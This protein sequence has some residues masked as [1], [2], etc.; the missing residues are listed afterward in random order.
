MSKQGACNYC[1]SSLTTSSPMPSC[2]LCPAHD[3]VHILVYM[4]PTCETAALKAGMS[5]GPC[6]YVLHAVY[7]LSDQ[8]KLTWDTAALKAG[9][10]SGP[11]AHTCA[12]CRRPGP[13]V[14]RWR[15]L[16]DPWQPP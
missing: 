12:A 11:P 2:P 6:T 9:M 16:R 5:S 10:S 7:S 13:P 3:L 4:Q 8:G 15:M 14:A 1:T